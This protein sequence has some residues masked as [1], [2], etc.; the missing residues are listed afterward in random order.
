MT[1]LQNDFA[2]HEAALSEILDEVLT[3]VSIEGL[4]AYDLSF[5]THTTGSVTVSGAWNG[6]V[7][8][9]LPASMDTVL[10]GAMFMMPIEEVGA[11]ELTDAIGEFANMVGGGVKSLMPEPSRLSLP[12]V[13]SGGDLQTSVP[14]G[15][16][17]ARAE[18]TSGG[19]ALRVSVWWNPS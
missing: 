15:V 3:S 1:A 16:L 12:T 17:L 13:V 9:E 8:V 10:T 19:G 2:V 5:A 4:P 11:E 18:R 14:G 6:S 7:L